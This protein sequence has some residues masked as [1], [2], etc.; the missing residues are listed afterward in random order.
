MILIDTNVF[1]YAAGKES[2]QREPCQR[3]LDEIVILHRY[4]S[5]KVPELGLQLFDA[6]IHLGIP[7][8]AVTDR[9]MTQARRILSEY[10]RSVHPG[11]SP[12]RKDELVESR[13]KEE[14]HAAMDA[15]GRLPAA[16]RRRRP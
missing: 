8:L 1:M 7:I 5:L 9:S 12:S 14:R 3:F 11:W 16:C 13:R 15:P 6:V 2:P 4:R 10:P